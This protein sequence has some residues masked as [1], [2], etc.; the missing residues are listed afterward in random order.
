MRKDT[1]IT[2]HPVEVWEQLVGVCSPSIMWVPGKELSHL[3][4]HPTDPRC[5]CPPQNIS[6]LLS[7]A[8]FS[9]SPSFPQALVESL[10]KSLPW[11]R[12]PMFAPSCPALYSYWLSTNVMPFLGLQPFSDIY[13]FVYWNKVSR[14]P[15]WPHTGCAAEDDLEFMI[16]LLPP[17]S[18]EVIYITLS[19][20]LGVLT[21]VDSTTKK[22]NYFPR[23]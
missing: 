15:G 7:H 16:L 8:A 18:T 11:L 17:A 4:S 23:M 20:M 5:V 12:L 1:C 22:Q 10:L 9:P 14:G 19:T 13:L 3:R 21:P 6:V 2:W